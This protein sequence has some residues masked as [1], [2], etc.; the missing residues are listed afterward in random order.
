MRGACCTAEQGKSCFFASFP[1]ET[2]ANTETTSFSDSSGD[3][4]YSFFP[5]HWFGVRLA[6]CTSRTYGEVFVCGNL[7]DCGGSGL[8]WYVFWP[9]TYSPPEDK[10]TPKP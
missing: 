1:P 3:R 8:C 7:G 10:N 6:V 4:V 9:S 5:F 2:A